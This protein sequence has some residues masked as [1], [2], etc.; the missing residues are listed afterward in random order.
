[1]DISSL[2]GV[3]IVLAAVN[4]SIVV[5]VIMDSNSLAGDRF[6]FIAAIASLI[7][8]VALTLAALYATATFFSGG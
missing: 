3:L 7:Q 6:R 8:S 4:W 5:A 1:M 2:Y